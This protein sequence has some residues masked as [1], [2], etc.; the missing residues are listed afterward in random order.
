MRYEK[1][2]GERTYY[3][4]QAVPDTKARTLYIVTAYI[5]ANKTGASQ[6]IDAQGSNVNVQ[7]GSVVA[8]KGK[9]SKNQENVNQKYSRELETVEALRRQNELLQ[10]QRDYW[11]EQTHTTDE[12]TRGADKGRSAEPCQPADPAVQQQDRGGGNSARDAMAG[13]LFPAHAG[14]IPARSMEKW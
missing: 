1:G 6:L 13:K 11:K 8:P 3:A 12:K 10:E 14:V 4:V 7:D 2:I 9:V 5:G